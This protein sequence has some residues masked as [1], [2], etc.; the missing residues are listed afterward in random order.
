MVRRAT[1]GDF[2]AILA[3]MIASVEPPWSETTLKSALENALSDAYVAVDGDKVVGYI[4]VENV[5]DEGCVT[6]VAVE[7]EYRNRGIGS[8]LLT[9]A[10]GHGKAASVY[11]EVNEKNAPAIAL[12]VSC[13]FEKVGER[14]K[15]YGSDSAFV[16]RREMVN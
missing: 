15:Y 4:I 10:L 13:G 2:G 5:L 1:E 11:L 16:M 14:K 12:Y 3:I 8:K 6:S 7:S 9:Y